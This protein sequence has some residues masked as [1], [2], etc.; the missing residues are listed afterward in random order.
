MDQQLLIAMAIELFSPGQINT[1]RKQCS[2]LYR[3]KP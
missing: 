3:W 1:V 2:R